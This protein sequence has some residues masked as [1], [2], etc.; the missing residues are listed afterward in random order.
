MKKILTML[1]VG[2]V[3]VV[4]YS[5]ALGEFD[6]NTF[7]IEYSLLEDGTV[8]ISKYS[9]N[10]TIVV[11]PGEIDGKKVTSIGEKTF[12]KN[13]SIVEIVISGEV[14]EIGVE[15]FSNC[16]NLKKVTLNDGLDIIKP[17]AFYRCIALNDIAFPD[18]VTKIGNGAF[19]ECES[20]TN[21]VLPNGVETIGKLS[22]SRC[23]S[24]ESISIPESVTVIEKAALYDCPLMIV[25]VSKGSFAEQYCIDNGYKYAYID[26]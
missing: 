4:I 1:L 16:V 21:I 3:L 10:E 14:M 5:F 26:E 15:A 17:S 24:L 23:T 9:G 6:T 12:Y 25:K 7:S 11:I 19:R 2:V 18:S 20:L 8:Q 22:F 13:E